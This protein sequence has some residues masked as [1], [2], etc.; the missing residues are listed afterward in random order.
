MQRFYETIFVARQ[1]LTANQVESLAKHYS[2]IITDHGGSI[3]KTE[4]IGLRTLAYKIKKNKKGYY[5][6]INITAKPEAIAEMERQMQLS[7]DILRFMSVR[8]D[9]LDNMP[10][11]LMQSRNFRDDSNNPPASARRA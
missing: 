9:E 5:V 10:S 7:E 2:Q 3:S 6:L 11:A 8:V 1:D 4:F